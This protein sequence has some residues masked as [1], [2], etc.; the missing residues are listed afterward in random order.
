[1][2][3]ERITRVG[4]GSWFLPGLTMGMLWYFLSLLSAKRKQNSTEMPVTIYH[5]GKL[6]R[7]SVANYA[8]ARRDRRIEFVRTGRSGSAVKSPKRQARGS[9]Y[10]WRR[11]LR[12]LVLSLSAM[13]SRSPDRNALIFQLQCAERRIKA[14][15]I[16]SRTW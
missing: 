6:A 16:A 11:L 13:S 4:N 14:L 2:C 8:A 15:K 7:R 3:P 10:S 9:K 5:C 1:M 12:N